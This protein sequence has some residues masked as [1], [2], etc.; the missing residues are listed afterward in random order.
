MFLGAKR[1]A[2]PAVVSELPDAAVV[3]PPTL[4][5]ATASDSRLA[6]DAPLPDA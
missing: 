1:A 3:A 2:A 5:V 6:L 4:A